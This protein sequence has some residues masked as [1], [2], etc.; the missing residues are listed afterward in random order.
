M[1]IPRIEHCSLR[2][3]RAPFSQPMPRA[4]LEWAY[5]YADGPSLSRTPSDDGSNAFLD[6]KTSLGAARAEPLF[7]GSN[8]I[9]GASGRRSLPR[10]WA[11]RAS[12]RRSS[13]LL[14]WTR[15]PPK[16]RIQAHGARRALLASLT[17]QALN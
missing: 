11:Q 13:R 17:A 1:R 16:R 6:G 8:W 4:E 9:T 5:P 10:A 2:S 15:S 3:S 14:C 7:S 12:S